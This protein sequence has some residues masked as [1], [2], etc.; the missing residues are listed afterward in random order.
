VS[1]VIRAIRGI[2]TAMAAPRRRAGRHAPQWALQ[3]AL[4]LALGSG[5]ASAQLGASEAS[6]K[7]AY[8]YNFAQFI[9]WPAELLPP[10]SPL[11]LCL[12]GADP[13]GAEADA[14]ASRRVRTHPVAVLRPT[15]SAELTSCHIAYTS[16]AQG[17]ARLLEGGPRSGLLVVSDDR[18]A[19]R[20]GATI[21]FVLQNQRLRWHLDHETARQ[22]GLSVSAKLLELSLPPPAP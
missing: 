19:L 14:L 11:R 1:G 17:S 6:L 2:R 3:W 8:L 7:L 16:G 15:R 20:R 4:M 9:D 13:F 12:L 21:Q 22:Q 5:A 18:G 10:G